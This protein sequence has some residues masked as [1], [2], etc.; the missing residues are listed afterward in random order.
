MEFHL[1][2]N[3]VPTLVQ[4]LSRL[5]DIARRMEQGLYKAGKAKLRLSRIPVFRKKTK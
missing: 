1:S 2:L 5:K 3:N 4:Q